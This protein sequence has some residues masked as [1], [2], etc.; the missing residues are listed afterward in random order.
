M[1]LTG[2]VDVDNHI[3]AF[4]NFE[5]IKKL[6]TI[7]RNLVRRAIPYIIDSNLNNPVKLACFSID[8][9]DLGEIELAREFIKLEI[10]NC[11]EWDY[12][13]IFNKYLR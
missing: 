11:E 7:S 2:I 5:A 3:I 8:L 13:T 12:Y 9:I 10:Q 1:S 6:L 4:C